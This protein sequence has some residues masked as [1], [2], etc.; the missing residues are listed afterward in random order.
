MTKT[1]EEKKKEIFEKTSLE[2]FDN[3]DG[4]ISMKKLMRNLEDAGLLHENQLPEVPEFVAEAIQS[5]PE[6]YTAIAAIQ[7]IKEKIEKYREN[8][9]DWVPVYKWLFDDINNQD[10]FALA[11]ITGNYTVQK[12][13]R[14]YLKDKLTGMFLYKMMT[15]DS[16]KTV[17]LYWN[18]V[19]D[20]GR[21]GCG[22][23]I[24]TQE[25]IDNM[26]A[27]SYEKIEVEE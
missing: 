12:P 8:N 6:Y 7:L 4:S 19:K 23:Y 11:F 10:V 14:F 16:K 9:E 24:F 2:E 5:L 26:D 13:K 1:F 18:I 21:V 25:E 3:K 20:E 27:G 15:G 22:N 17:A